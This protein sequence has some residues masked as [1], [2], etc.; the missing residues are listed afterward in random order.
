M[1]IEVKQGDNAE[2][3]TNSSVVSITSAIIMVCTCNLFSY[4]MDCAR[5]QWDTV[6]TEST[7]FQNSVLHRGAV[8][9]IISALQQ[10]HK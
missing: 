9:K 1:V 4:L 8:A 5:T 2:Q 7:N 10:C 6:R 3:F